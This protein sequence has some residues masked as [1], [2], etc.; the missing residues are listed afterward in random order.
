MKPKLSINAQSLLVLGIMASILFLP[1]NKQERKSNP[2]ELVMKVARE[3]GNWI[4]RIYA[5]GKPYIVQTIIPALQGNIPFSDSVSAAKVGNLVLQK[6]KSGKIPAISET[7][8][9]LL[10]IL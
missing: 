2:P 10:G 8:L 6:L 9:E 7:E 4:Y 5:G 3:G 1:E